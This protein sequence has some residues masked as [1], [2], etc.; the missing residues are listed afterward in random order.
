MK[1]FIYIIGKKNPEQSVFRTETRPLSIESLSLRSKK[2]QE[3]RF[4]Q[5]RQGTATI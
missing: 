3:I 1:T 2:H 5:T 4:Q